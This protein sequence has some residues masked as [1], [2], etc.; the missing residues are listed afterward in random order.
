MATL[1]SEAASFCP[2]AHRF[3]ST[4]GGTGCAQA[5]RRGD[6]GAVQLDAHLQIVPLHLLAVQIN[7]TFHSKELIKFGVLIVN[8]L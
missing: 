8:E 1:N 4:P 3:F 2:S 5:G 7:N 6:A